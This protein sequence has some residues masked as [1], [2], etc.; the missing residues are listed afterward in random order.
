MMTN[1]SPHLSITL[2]QQR[3]TCVL[4]PSL[5]LSH[6]GLLLVKSLGEVM[7]LWVPRE[8]LYILDNP[9]FYLQ[10]PESVL[11]KTKPQNS[12]ELQ[13]SDRFAVQSAERQEV[14]QVLKDWEYIRRETNP[15]NLKLFWIGDKLGESFL[16][17][18]ADLQLI[19]RWESLAR[20]LDN[21]LNKL[22]VTNTTLTSALRDTATLATAL[23]S[24]FILT[25]QLTENNGINLSA[26]GI[27]V[28][29]ESWEIPCQQIDAH[30]PIAAIER[31]NLLHLIIQA[32]LSKF[33]W[34]GLNLAVLHLVV[35]SASLRY[36]PEENQETQSSNIQD[37]TEESALTPN[38]W[39]GARGFWYRFRS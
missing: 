5:F 22:S 9:N 31:E 37:H 16:P 26:P 15:A 23:N 10:Q 36:D 38:L 2:N 35:P 28:A 33:L 39:E 29:L 32:G 21:Q 27:C 24:A 13:S 1:S 8:L 14:V 7:D 17:S 20:S 18:H 11:F 34:A 3:F 25:Y 12:T 6:Y 19:Y 30:D 4:D